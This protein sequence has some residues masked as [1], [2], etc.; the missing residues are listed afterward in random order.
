MTG[1]VGDLE[2]DAKRHEE[3]RRGAAT[4]PPPT[5]PTGWCARLGLPF[6][7]AHHVTGRI[8][9]LADAKGCDLAKP[10]A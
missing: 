1:M 3:G 9:A 7:E 4:R 10:H 6:R 2:P 8:V 5:S